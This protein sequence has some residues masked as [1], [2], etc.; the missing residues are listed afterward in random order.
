MGLRDGLAVPATAQPLAQARPSDRL[1][2]MEKSLLALASALETA[3]ETVASRSVETRQ[4]AAT[5]Q[6]D[7]A[8]ME[9]WT[10][11]RDRVTRLSRHRTCRR[12]LTF[13]RKDDQ[14]KDSRSANEPLQT[15]RRSVR[16]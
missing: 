9:H 1:T 11:V 16:C 8:A 13:R 6:P 10:V 15:G 14:L 7:T 3:L 2:V 5:E 4:L 12:W